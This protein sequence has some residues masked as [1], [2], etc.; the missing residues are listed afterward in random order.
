MDRAVSTVIRTGHG[1][2]VVR[3][4]KPK[5]NQWRLPKVSI[6]ID[7]DWHEE[8]SIFIRKTTGLRIPKGRFLALKEDGESILCTAAV[9]DIDVIRDIISLGEGGIEVHEVSYY[10]VNN[11]SSVQKPVR[12]LLQQQ[13]L[14][15]PP[16]AGT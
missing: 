12:I 2:V 5:E 6:A 3:S 16:E 13:K 11:G 10:L 7:A 15:R 4:R 8:N 1:I 9:S 14:N